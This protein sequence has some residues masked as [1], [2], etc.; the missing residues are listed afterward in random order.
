MIPLALVLKI[1]M[2]PPRFLLNV[3]NSIVYFTLEMSLSASVAA[4]LL[5]AL[6]KHW[7]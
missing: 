1:A 3:N 2:A 7:V 6:L 5:F 4:A